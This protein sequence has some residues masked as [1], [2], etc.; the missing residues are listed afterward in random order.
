[1]LDTRPKTPKNSWPVT[2]EITDILPEIES[3]LGEYGI[4]LKSTD[5]IQYGAKI[6]VLKEKDLGELNVYY[7]RQGYKVVSSPRK[8][9]H[10]ELNEVA[11]Q[12]IE[13]VVMHY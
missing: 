13:G 9:T 3:A 1:M 11:K 7:G 12:I 4:S 10:H 2:K 6:R 8:G 5:S